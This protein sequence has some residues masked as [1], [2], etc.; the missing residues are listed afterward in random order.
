MFNK[1]QCSLLSISPRAS[2]D[3]NDTLT[4]YFIN[5]LP[6]SPCNRQKDLGILTS[7]NL[8]WTHRISRITTKAYQILGLLRHT[9]ISSNNVTTKKKLYLSLERSQLI[10]AWIPNLETTPT[11]KHQHNRTYPTS[12]NSLRVHIK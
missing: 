10:Y 9:F 3:H 5:G 2:P 8:L 7:S 6:I 12:C 11:K 1:T 4:E